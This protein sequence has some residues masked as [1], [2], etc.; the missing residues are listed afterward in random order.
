MSAAAGT[1]V[2]ESTRH[3]QALAGLETLDASHLP[4]WKRALEN[5]RPLGFGCY[6]PFVLTHNRPGRSAV[7]L[8]E[9]AGSLCVFVLSERKRGPRLDVFLAPIPMDVGA[10]RRCLERANDFNGD[11]S[12]R[13]LRIDAH[14][15]PRVAAIPGLSVR[16]R[17][18][19]YLYAPRD[20]GDLRG[21]K[22]R[23]LRSHVSRVRRMPGLEVA[24]YAERFHEECTQ[25]LGRWAER[26]RETFG[27]SGAVRTS[28]RLLRM[29]GRLAAPDLFGE[30]VRM[31]GR[32][33][34]F[35]FGGEIHAGLGSFVE[36]KSEFDV[37]GL[38][39]FLR[40]DFLSK[41][42]FELV[43]D[44][45]DARRPGLRQLKNSLRPV[46][47]HLEHRATQEAP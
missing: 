10:A 42:E 41:M 14:D 45:S 32:L 23:T 46:A 5:G 28:A 22:Y 19:Q 25:L 26:H 36:A 2:T 40:H 20:I 11:R 44:G 1:R 12:A 9:D 34:A 4:R 31:D 47:M 29:A 27:T 38:A 43:N 37:H 35:A 24:P 18:V 13:I 7:L 3:T 17:R 39:Y 16:K 21:G 15:A 6:F 30:V 8:S 33:V